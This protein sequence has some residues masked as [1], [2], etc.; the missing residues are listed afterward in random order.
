[1][2]PEALAEALGESPKVRLTDAAEA[3]PVKNAVTTGMPTIIC[4]QAGNVNSGAFDPLD[5][6][7]D[8]A[9]RHHAWLHV[10]GAFGLWAA[11]S[12]A[13]THH[14][15]GI[16]RADSC[17]TDAHKWLNVPYDSGLVFVA[18]P[19]AH[20]AAMSLSAAYLVRSPE[21]P[22]EPMDWVPESSRRA[23]GFAVY[24]A[25]RSLGRSG[26][27]DLVDRCCRLARRFADRLQQEPSIRILNEVVLNQVLVRVVP[28]HGDA[29]VA[30]RDT[31]R[32][33]QQDGVCWLGGS[34]WHGMDAMR[35]SVSNWSTSEADIDRSADSIIRA[36]RRLPEGPT[37]VSALGAARPYS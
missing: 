12:G 22:R 37:D 2:K 30:T 26:V 10:D 6:I 20:R 18:H 24:A 16:A 1:M 25:L 28:A 8:L 32:L 27:A 29:D 19:A 36:V 3:T 23:R 11:A 14:V 33:V 21:E 31:L 7:A 9:A 35:I 5:A 15:R 17:A 4:A 34:H 13:L